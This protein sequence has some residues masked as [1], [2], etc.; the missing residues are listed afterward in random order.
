M[1]MPRICPDRVTEVAMFR[2]LS[3]ERSQVTINIIIGMDNPS[4]LQNPY[5]IIIE[6]MVG[7]KVDTSIEI[8]AMKY[9]T[10]QL[11]KSMQLL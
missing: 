11:L 8:A 1:S 5:I 4:P 2:F 3:K 6:Y 7:E 10:T 9:P